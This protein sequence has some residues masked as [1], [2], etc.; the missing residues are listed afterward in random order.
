LNFLQYGV[1]KLTV[2]DYH[3]GKNEEGN[4]VYLNFSYPTYKGLK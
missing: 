3:F 2:T 1:D 4:E